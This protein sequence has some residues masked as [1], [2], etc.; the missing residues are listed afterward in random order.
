MCRPLSVV[1]VLA[2][3]LVAAP[4]AWAAAW[5]TSRA[6]T[7]ARAGRAERG[8]AAAGI[9][10]PLRRRPHRPWHARGALGE[11]RGHLAGR[12]DAQPG[13]RHPALRRLRA[14]GRRM[15][16]RLPQRAEPHEHGHPAPEG[17]DVDTR[18]QPEPRLRRPALRRRDDAR[19]HVGGRHRHRGGR[20]QPSAHPALDRQGV[21][22]AAGARAPE[23]K[24]PGLRHRR[25][26]LR[27]VGVRAAGGERRDAPSAGAAPHRVGL[28]RLQDAGP[29]AWRR[30]VLLRGDDLGRRPSGRSEAAAPGRGTP[31]RSGTPRRA[32]RPSPCPTA[33]A[34]RPRTSSPRSS[35]SRARSTSG[36]SA[37]APPASATRPSSSGAGNGAWHQ[38]SSPT[39]DATGSFLTGVVAFSQ[40]RAAAVG[41]RTPAGF[42]TLALIYH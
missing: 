27:P 22:D 14:V 34:A 40:T 32:G 30:V 16:R 31:S 11:R 24:Q 8:R 35:R 3:L 13:Y 7:P 25:E 42:R 37:T 9:E 12:A 4:A 38:V 29:G 10:R 1:A 39:P 41:Y 26:G 6:A 5:S 20:E 17:R 21:E 36:R 19:R 28:A 15:G 23:G 33:Q 18:P 2:A